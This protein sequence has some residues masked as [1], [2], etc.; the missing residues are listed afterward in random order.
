MPGEEGPRMTL[1][2]GVPRA[3]SQTHSASVAQADPNNAGED[4]ALSPP[5]T[6]SIKRNEEQM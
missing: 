2:P 1:P 6:F 4:T 3:L 5:Q